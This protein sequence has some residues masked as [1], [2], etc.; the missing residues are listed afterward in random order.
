MLTVLSPH[1]DD[2]AYALAMALRRVALKGVTIELINC[3]TQ[4]DHAPRA[5]VNANLD[6][7]TLR[8]DEDAA[9]IEHLSGQVSA[10]YLGLADTSARTGYDTLADAFHKRD[11][12]VHE[13]EIMSELHAA[14]V[15]SDVGRRVDHAVL[16]PMA[17]G[18]HVDHRLV[19]AVAEELVSRERIIYYEDMPYSYAAPRRSIR[20]HLARDGV[21]PV[22]I[23]GDDE[24][25]SQKDR[26]IQLYASQLEPNYRQWIL[27]RGRQLGGERVWL[28]ERALEALWS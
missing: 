18:N 22:I 26:A 24:A 9:F 25:L 28:S 21:E 23:A 7:S 10:R 12:V 27:D 16:V 13:Q 2:A 4:S 1:I 11:F 5:T 20:K 15:D 14:L 17:Y 19:R 8:A 6:I 3:F